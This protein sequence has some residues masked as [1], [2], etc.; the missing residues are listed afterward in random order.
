MPLKGLQSNV[1]MLDM[2]APKLDARHVYDFANL[3][4]VPHKPI[5]AL[6]AALR[7]DIDSRDKGILL[8]H[9]HAV[10]FLTWMAHEGFLGIGEATLQNLADDQG[11]AD[12]V[13]GFNLPNETKL[14][15]QLM[16]KLAPDKTPQEVHIALATR[17]MHDDKVQT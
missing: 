2:D 11:V 6:H 12:V 5:S 4:V 10:D 17:D 9:G 15:F 3:Q 7:G 13:D 1:I 16:Q 14:V 8:E